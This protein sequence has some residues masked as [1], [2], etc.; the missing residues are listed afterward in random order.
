MTCLRTMRVFAALV[1]LVACDSV[2]APSD[3][4][5]DAGMD[6][7]HEPRCSRSEECSNGFCVG[8]RCADCDPGTHAGCGGATPICVSAT[9]TCR[10]CS[11]DC[12]EGLLCAASGACERCDADANE[13]PSEAPICASSGRC[14][15]CSADVQ[16]AAIDETTVCATT[17]EC[18]VCDPTTHH[19]CSGETPFCVGGAS[20]RGCVTNAECAERRPGEVCMRSGACA[21]CDDDD[22]RGCD[23]DPTRPFC[24][25]G[26]GNVC[27]G[28][29]TDQECRYW[30]DIG[31][32]CVASGPD[33]GTCVCTVGTNE[34]CQSRRPHCVDGR[35]CGDCVMDDHCRVEDGFRCV[36]NRCTCTDDD[37]CSCGP[38]RCESGATCEHLGLGLCYAA[39]PS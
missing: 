30:P 26:N 27:R 12:P 17:G 20:C 15:P 19:G 11:G 31:D 36:D 25:Y 23:D 24:D 32:I 8:G 16:C 13:C 3:G 39:P 4:G 14:T 29:E 21:D 28:C 18:L 6:A 7:A 9:L 5:V 35:R 38:N 2:S 33:A 1:S 37:G 22:G 10:A 34:G